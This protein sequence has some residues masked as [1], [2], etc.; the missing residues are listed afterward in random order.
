MIKFEPRIEYRVTDIHVLTIEDSWDKGQLGKFKSEDCDW[1]KVEPTEFLSD[2]VDTIT[3]SFGEDAYIDLWDN[4]ITVNLLVDGDNCE[5]S[6]GQ[7]EEWRKGNLRLWNQDYTFYVEKVIVDSEP[8]LV[9]ILAE[10]TQ[11]VF[12]KEK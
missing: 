9:E 11:S 10:E 2:M 1:I 4:K 12:M 5:S 3:E 8:D 6:E 7:R